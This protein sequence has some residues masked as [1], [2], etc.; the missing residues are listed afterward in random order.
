VSIAPRLKRRTPSL[1]TRVVDAGLAAGLTIW[2][3]LETGVFRDPGRAVVLLSMTVAIAGLRSAPVAVLA[4][5]V[6]GVVLLPKGL[7]W[8][9][10]VAVLTAGY[11]AAFYSDRRV[12]VGALLVGAAVWLLA[13]GGQVTIP[14][15]LVPIVLVA[16]LWLAGTAMRRRE[17]RAAAW[18]ERA[19][20]LEWE[21]E[22]AL[23]TERAR[24]ARELHDVVTH[25][26]SVMVLQTGA[27][28]EIMTKDEHRSRELL[29]SVERSGRQALDELRRMLGVLAEH[30]R[31]APLS[32]QPDVTQIPALVD[33]VRQAGAAVEL[34]VEGDPRVVPGG[35]AV[36]AYRIVQEALTNVLKHASGASSQ[37]VVRWADAALELEVVDHGP[38]SEAA[39]SDAPAGRGLAGMRERAAMYGGTLDA[40]PGPDRGYVVRARI[41]LEGGGP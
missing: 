26:V 21:R 18:E 33:R 29:E 20:R 2:A 11:A 24:I 12:L 17:Q 27:A 7:H 9:Q 39:R 36:A 38:P 13:F 35:A 30:D 5:E 23:R 22:A 31:E 19:D 6:A 16:P 28:R 34:S 1:D 8:P 14:S 32:P 41:P 3:V 25:S 37:V 40:H 10:G 15:G 4:V